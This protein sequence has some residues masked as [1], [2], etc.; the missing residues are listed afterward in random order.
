MTDAVVE[1]LIQDLLEWLATADRSY[2]DVMDA[3]RRSC[4]GLPVWEEANDRGLLIREDMN[5]RG[6]ARITSSG[7]ALPAQRDSK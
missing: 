3:W 1:N 6:V 5:G 7:R 2:D 4:P